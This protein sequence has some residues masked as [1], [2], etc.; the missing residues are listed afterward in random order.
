MVIVPTRRAADGSRVLGLPKGHV[1][2]GE[3]APQ[4][5]RR[6]VREETG[7]EAELVAELGELRYWYRRAGRTI[8]KS[9]A[10][11]LFRYVGGD[12]ADH[13]AEV[14]EARWISLAEAR[15]ALSYA[16]EREMVER[17]LVLLAR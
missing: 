8:P 16:G 15:T 14:E 2:P 1:D 5:A 11:Y 12:T 4:A 3:S 13:D 9:V 6:E 17:A 10:F 7:I